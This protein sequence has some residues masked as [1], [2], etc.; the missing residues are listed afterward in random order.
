MPAYILFKQTGMP[1]YIL[2]QQTRIHAIFWSRRLD[3]LSIFV[4]SRR[5]MNSQM[6]LTD[7]LAPTSLYNRKANIK[8]AL[9]WKK[10]VK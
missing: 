5:T 6:T 2:V 7:L 3:C 8:G 9:T 1:D 4:S 10:C